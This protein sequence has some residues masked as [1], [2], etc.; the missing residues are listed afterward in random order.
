MVVVTNGEIVLKD[1]AFRM[2]VN[3]IEKDIPAA[4]GELRLMILNVL[5]V[6]PQAVPYGPLL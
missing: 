4:I 6:N 3:V 5:P 1:K 2:F